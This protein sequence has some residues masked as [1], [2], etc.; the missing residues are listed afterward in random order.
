MVDYRLHRAALVPAR[1]NISPKI[2]FILSKAGIIGSRRNVATL[3]QLLR[4]MQIGLA[5]HAGWLVFPDSRRLMKAE[6]GRRAMGAMRY[7]QLCMHD[8]A[9]LGRKRNLLARVSWKIR[10]SSVCTF[11]GAP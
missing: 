6:S 4:I 8:A 5:A 2:S 11:K 9:R 1:I 10:F 3:R 7:Q